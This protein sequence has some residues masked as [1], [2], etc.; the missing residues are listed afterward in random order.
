LSLE[1]AVDASDG[2]HQAVALH[3]LV[4]VHRVQARRIEAGQPHIAH[5]DEL[6]R[7]FRITSALGEQIASHLV[8]DVLL[9]CRWIAGCAGHDDLHGAGLVVGARASP[10]AA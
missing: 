7:I 4:H 9:P 1:H 3:R 10:G 6:Q 8:A 5:D 2:L